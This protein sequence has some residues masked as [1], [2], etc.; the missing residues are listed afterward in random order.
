MCQGGLS[1]LHD[2]RKLRSRLNNA[3]S[4]YRVKGRWI[5]FQQLSARLIH[6]Q[7]Y[8][9][10]SR[11]I[12]LREQDIYNLFLL[13]CLAL[14]LVRREMAWLGIVFFIYLESQGHAICCVWVHLFFLPLT[15]KERR[16]TIWS[17]LESNQSPPASQAT[18]LTTRPCLLEQDIYK[19]H[20]TITVFIVAKSSSKTQ[21][22]LRKKKLFLKR[23]SKVVYYWNVFLQ[24]LLHNVESD[25]QSYTI[26]ATLVKLV[27]VIVGL[28][29]NQETLSLQIR[30]YQV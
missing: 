18:A 3:Y 12:I 5:G 27:K 19:Y 11:K 10:V 24:E 15:P 16:K 30:N 9:T 26:G 23:P 8:L 4:L 25:Q 14:T 29:T 1:S 2:R 22:I 21:Q 6:F 20:K 17:E 13:P 7:S 28:V